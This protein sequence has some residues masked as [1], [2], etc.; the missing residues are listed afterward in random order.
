MPAFDDYDMQGKTYRYFGGTPLFPF[1]HGLS[2]TSFNYA[3][4]N[5][6]TNIKAGETLKVEFTVTNTGKVDG[7]EVVQ[8]YVAHPDFPERKAIRSLQGFERVFLKAGESKTM[9]F[10]LTPAQMA[11]RDSDNAQVVTPGN[12]LLSIGGAQPDVLTITN[13]TVV[14]TNIELKGTQFVVR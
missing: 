14:T 2:Y 6:P 13:K 10:E 1:G 7:E 11:V 3:W 8:L 12:L 4:K 5:K 9:S